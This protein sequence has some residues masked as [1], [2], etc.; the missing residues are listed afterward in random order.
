MLHGPPQMN[1]LQLNKHKR[2]KLGC[3][4]ARLKK[5]GNK[6]LSECFDTVV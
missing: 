4:V 1:V 6:K 5:Y 2:K 3:R